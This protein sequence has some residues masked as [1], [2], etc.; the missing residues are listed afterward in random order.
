VSTEPDAWRD[1]PRSKRHS[2]TVRPLHRRGFGATAALVAAIFGGIGLVVSLTGLAINLLPRHFNPSQQRQIVAWEVAKRW[3]TLP[4]GDIF[5]ANVSYQLSALALND[6][7]PVPLQA[8]RVGIAPQ[9]S[10]AAGTDAAA[11]RVLDARGCQALLRATY[12]DESA[13]YVVTV[14]VA[15][16]VG[17]ALGD[18]PFCTKMVTVEPF[19]AVPLAGCWLKTVPLATFAGPDPFCTLTWKP[20]LVRIW[21]AVAWE[22]PTT[23]G[24]E[25]APPD[26]A[27]PI[28]GP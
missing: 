14:G 15:V 2:G 24:T 12:T 17:G 13:T 11:A 25:I 9:T 19:A 8:A 18:C 23:D 4:A 28:P 26:G 10:C 6:L 5:P 1:G 16:S 21:L 22:S 27:T 3:R 7:T 20:A